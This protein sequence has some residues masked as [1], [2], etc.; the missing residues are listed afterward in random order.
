MT[1]L[2]NLD[3][4]HLELIR[5][6]ASRLSVSSEAVV[7]NQ[8]LDDIIYAIQDDQCAGLDCLDLMA[9]LAIKRHYAELERLNIEKA[10]RLIKFRNYWEQ[11]I[12]ELG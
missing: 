4:L 5:L 6:V 10:T 8:G 12:A 11:Q 1:K 3:Y 2:E 7:A 9:E